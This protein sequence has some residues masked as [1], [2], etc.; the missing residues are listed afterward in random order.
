MKNY[1]VFPK[2]ED[3][4]HYFVIIKEG[5]PIGVFTNYISAIKECND[6]SYMIYEMLLNKSYTINIDIAG[7]LVNHHFS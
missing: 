1:S 3:L 6:N 7:N 4:P 5:L 2:K